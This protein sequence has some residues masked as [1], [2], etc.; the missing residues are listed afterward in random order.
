MWTAASIRRRDHPSRPNAYDLLSLVPA[1][2]IAHVDGG[3]SSRLDQCPGS[4][5][6]LAGFQVIIIGRIWVIPEVKAHWT[7]SDIDRR[8][9]LNSVSDSYNSLFLDIIS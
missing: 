6:L 5:C 4:A 9:Q 1:Q 8:Q 3:Y 7:Q 2:D